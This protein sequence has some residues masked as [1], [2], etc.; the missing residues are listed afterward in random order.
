MPIEFGLSTL[1]RGVLVSREA[2][3]ERVR[4]AAR[5]LAREGYL[6]EDDVPLSVAAAARLWDH[7]TR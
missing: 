7:F 1:S 5:A 2:Y 3:L 6:L 4:E